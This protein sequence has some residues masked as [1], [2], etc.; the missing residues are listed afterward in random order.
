MVSLLEDNS[1]GDT[2]LNPYLQILNNGD[3][4]GQSRMHDDLGN[5]TIEH[6]DTSKASSEDFILDKNFFF[7]AEDKF[8]IGI[9]AGDVNSLL[10]QF[11]E[12]EAASS[13]P[14]MSV[15]SPTNNNLCKKSAET[16][17]KTGKQQLTSFSIEE[18]TKKIAPVKRKSTILLENVTLPLK[19]N[20]KP[21][22][23]GLASNSLPSSLPSSHPNSLPNSAPN[24]LPASQPSSCN[25]SRSCSPILWNATLLDHDYCF[26]PIK[27]KMNNNLSPVSGNKE[28]GDVHDMPSVGKKDEIKKE[29]YMGKYK[30]K[31]RNHR[32]RHHHH[33][34]HN[35]KCRHSHQN[36]PDV[37]MISNPNSPATA[38][39]QQKLDQMYQK[40]REEFQRKFG[41]L[42]VP[43]I[44]EKKTLKIQSLNELPTSLRTSKDSVENAVPNED[45]VKKDE[46]EDLNVADR[47][48]EIDQNDA[49]RI[50][51]LIDELK[52]TRNIVPLDAHPTEV[53]LMNAAKTTETDSETSDKTDM[54]ENNLIKQETEINNFTAIKDVDHVPE[55]K[56]NE[57]LA[58][59][60]VTTTTNDQAPTET[61][62]FKQLSEDEI[63]PSPAPETERTNER[64][65]IPQSN[66][67]QTNITE[68]VAD[69]QTESKPVEIILKVDTIDMD[70]SDTE[71]VAVFKGN[72]FEM[73]TS[74]F[75]NEQKPN[76][77]NNQLN[78][79]VCDGESGEISSSDENDG[80]KDKQKVR[81]H[82]PYRRSQSRSQ[83]FTKC[84]SRSRSYE[85]SRSQRSRRNR[86][87][88]H[89]SRSFHSRSRNSKSLQG[90]ISRSRSRSISRS[91]SR[92]SS[93]RRLEGRRSRLRYRRSSHSSCSVSSGASSHCSRRRRS[94]SCSTCPSRS[95]SRSRSRSFSRSHSRKRSWRSRSRLRSH[96]RSR[97][98]SSRRHRSSERRRR[99]LR[100]RSVSRERRLERQKRQ[101]KEW[102]DRRVLY[103]GNI[104]EGTTKSEI[105]SRFSKFGNITRITLHFR[106]EGDNYCFV[107]FAYTCD[108]YAAVEF[109]NEDPTYPKYEICFGGRRSFCR[110]SYADLDNMHKEEDELKYGYDG[111]APSNIKT[112]SV[113]E[114]D[115]D[116]LLKQ[117]LKKV[118]S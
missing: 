41:K 3:G 89:R 30:I 97:S 104:K 29:L 26:S 14:P 109:G 74:E 51:A 113:K 13:T 69:C 33:H 73:E 50:N 65:H 40:A 58:E 98:R 35:E 64:A 42:E 108:A 56:V 107:T 11:E 19:R 82:S 87:R 44:P 96:S 28:N 76:E 22:L 103:I 45:N 70:F 61:K 20:R 57:E 106:D 38:N 101:E 90:R 7:Q 93:T 39:V 91:H 114:T 118:K 63:L 81:S 5:I 21:N 60:N 85:R 48:M 15:T 62:Q 4:I 68:S 2:S 115:F 66:Q 25:S 100:D 52:K 6:V 59:T 34:H 8:D 31:K 43:S 1:L 94:R 83:S 84:R 72:E 54:K 27:T 10:E 32:H 78:L 79:A 112:S 17:R 23:L 71:A 55:T 9:E 47:K 80:H 24:S 67:A 18:I 99:Y 111:Q 37:R 36:V 86:S 95:C 53:D 88:T 92:S 49:N 117:A 16:E 116:L 77:I 12:S 102:E 46:Q 105:N 75:R 110:T